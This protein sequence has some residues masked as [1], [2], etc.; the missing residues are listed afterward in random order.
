MKLS[1]FR[2]GENSRRDLILGQWRTSSTSREG[3]YANLSVGT[4]S[5]LLQSSITIFLIAGM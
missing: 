4:S 3:K 5:K 1:F 2:D